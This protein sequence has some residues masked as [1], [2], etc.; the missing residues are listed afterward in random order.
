[1]IDKSKSDAESN[2]QVPGAKRR[3]EKL[4]QVFLDAS[5]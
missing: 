4:Y 2:N 5:N 3:F 1:M